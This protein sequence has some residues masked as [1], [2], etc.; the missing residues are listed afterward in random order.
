MANASYIATKLGGLDAPV[1]RVLDDIFTYILSNLRIGR[2][3]ADSRS[4]N[5]QMYF[6]EATTP[7]VAN[8]EFS[9]P[10]GLGRAPYLAIPVLPLDAGAKLVRLTVSRAPD[11]ARVYLSSP[12]TSAPVTILI[13]G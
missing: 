3:T 4:E 10:H 13:E 5:L 11:A 8:T 1:R 6:L 9:L 2:P 12:D 7:A